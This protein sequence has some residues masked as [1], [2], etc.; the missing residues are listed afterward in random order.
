MYFK[1]EC[2]SDTEDFLTNRVKKG[3]F[4][5]KISCIRFMI[6][7]FVVMAATEMHAVHDI[8]PVNRRTDRQQNLSNVVPILP[9]GYG[10][11]ELCCYL[12]HQ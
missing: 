6:D 8:Q 1:F 12:P 3:K 4:A 11:Q 2:E 7:S 9:L 5:K 10:S